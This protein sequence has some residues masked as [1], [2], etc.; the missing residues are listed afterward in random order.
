[1]TIQLDPENNEINALHE[2]ADFNNGNVLEIGCG[3]GR[4]TWRYAARAAHVVAVDPGIDGLRRAR[5]STPGN[6]KGRV[7]FI[8]DAFLDMSAK[9]ETSSFD[10]AI[11]SWSL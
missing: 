1:M 5:A 2:L 4:L 8:Q 10:L 6:L 11:L 9:L 7:E 3:D